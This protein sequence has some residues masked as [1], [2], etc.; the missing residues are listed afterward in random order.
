M[1]ALLCCFVFAVAERVC[2]V[3][4]AANLRR[5]IVCSRHCCLLTTVVIRCP[6]LFVLQSKM[7]KR[8]SGY[9]KKAS[10]P[11]PAP[12]LAKKPKYEDDFDFESDDANS[13]SSESSNG[14]FEVEKENP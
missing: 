5:I 13:S 8:R 7:P 9:K 6:S 12:K 11:K 10:K 3:A 14:S 2:A 1:S 4:V